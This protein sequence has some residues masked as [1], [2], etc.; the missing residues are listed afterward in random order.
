MLDNGPFERLSDKNLPKDLRG[1]FKDVVSSRLESVRNR[2]KSL[3]FRGEFPPAST[4]RRRRF[5]CIISALFSFFLEH[6][7]FLA[8]EFLRGVDQPFVDVPFVVGPGRVNGARNKNKHEK[9]VHRSMDARVLLPPRFD[10]FFAKNCQKIDQI[11]QALRVGSS[12]P[13]PRWI[14]P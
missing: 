6:W 5:C 12:S 1:M 4:M 11:C 2:V 3:V 8:L 10:Q 13:H 14:R 9:C 7:N